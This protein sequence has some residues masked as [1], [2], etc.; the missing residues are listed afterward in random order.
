ME[1]LAHKLLLYLIGSAALYS[2]RIRPY[3]TPDISNMSYVLKV[4]N[5]DI[6]VPLTTPENLWTLKEFNPNLP[7]VMM[8]TGWT[9]NFNDPENPTL[10][11]IYNAYSCR[12]N[13]N[14]VVRFEVKLFVPKLTTF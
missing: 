14:F 7:L 1:N 12:G 4:K 13:Y 9:T 3:F 8:I 10:D 6:R 11:K 2:Q 5:V